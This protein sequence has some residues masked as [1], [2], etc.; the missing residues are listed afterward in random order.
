MYRQPWMVSWM[1]LKDC[2]ANNYNFLQDDL[3]ECLTKWIKWRTT[4]S[5]TMVFHNVANHPFLNTVNRPN[6][7]YIRKIVVFSKQMLSIVEDLIAAIPYY[8]HRNQQN[9]CCAGRLSTYNTEYF[10]HGILSNNWM[11]NCLLIGKFESKLIWLYQGFQLS[12][13]N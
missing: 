2:L 5:I 1:V 7:W 13:S 10:H 4:D 11:N 12:H 6:T 9:K 8:L 3:A